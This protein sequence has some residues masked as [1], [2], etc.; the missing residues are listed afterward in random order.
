MIEM[1]RMIMRSVP[2]NVFDV[3]KT[4]VLTILRF[5]Q[6]G[7]CHSA[8][9][10]FAVSKPASGAFLCTTSSVWT[11]HC[12]IRPVLRSSAVNRAWKRC[13]KLWRHTRNPLFYSIL[14]PPVLVE[15]LEIMFGVELFI[16]TQANKSSLVHQTVGHWWAYEHTV[17][18]L[19]VYCNYYAF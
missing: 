11:L 9:W 12:K 6:C 4:M 5:N 3:C 17:G 19:D 16:D 7:Q 2:I 10:A 13:K 18:S 14:R 8:S 1:K 15:K